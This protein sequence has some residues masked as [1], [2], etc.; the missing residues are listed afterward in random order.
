MKVYLILAD[1]FE[2]IEA[3]TIIDLLRRGNVEIESVTI[4]T[5][6]EVTGAHGISIKSDIYMSD[7]DFKNCCMIILPGGMPGT[8]NL[9]NCEELNNQILKL[10][11]KG[12][13]ICAIC[14]APMILADKGILKGKKATIYPNMEKGLKETANWVDDSV[15]KDGNIITSQ[16]PGT[17]MEFALKLVEILRGKKEKEKVRNEILFLSEN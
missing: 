12:A 2:E 5:N 17:A 8:I 11:E 9:D 10:K 6:L 4:T 7:A 16:G 1:G 13:Y 15:V 3:I 14:A